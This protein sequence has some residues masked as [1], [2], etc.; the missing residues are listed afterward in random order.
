VLDELLDGQGR[1]RGV[2]IVFEGLDGAGTTTQAETLASWLSEQGNQVEL[3]GEPST[4]PI[5]GVTRSIIDGRLSTD[6]SALALMFAAD[7]V[8]HLYNSANGIVSLLRGGVSVISDRYVLSSLAYQAV[9]GMAVEWLLQIN[10]AAVVPDVT[11]FIDAEVGVCLAR[12]TRRSKRDELFHS[13]RQLKLIESAYKRVLSHG[14][15]IGSLVTADGNQDRD[16]VSK[17][18]RTGLGELADRQPGSVIGR[19]WR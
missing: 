5:G 18:V 4:G 2:F 3:T 12:I 6:P 10:A 11:V 8:D 7:R 9:Q 1:D 14:E 13:R 15:F 17:Q 19:L 16:T